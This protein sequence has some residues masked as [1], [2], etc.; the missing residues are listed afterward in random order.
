M[1]T[2]IFGRRRSPLKL[3]G[4][5]QHLN[6]LNHYHTDANA[7]TDIYGNYNANNISHYNT[8][9][10]ANANTNTNILNHYNADNDILN[11]CN[12]IQS[13]LLS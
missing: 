7:N 11:Q 5:L 12:T 6:I 10:N 4:P 3:Q 8:Y 13:G 9:A 1:F 2:L